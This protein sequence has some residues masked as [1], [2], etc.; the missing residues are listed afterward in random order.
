MITIRKS[1]LAWVLVFSVLLCGLVLFSRGSSDFKHDELLDL[2]SG[3]WLFSTTKGLGAID[4]I[5]NSTLG[6]GRFC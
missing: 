2:T 6:V 1:A 3:G 5:Q 4:D